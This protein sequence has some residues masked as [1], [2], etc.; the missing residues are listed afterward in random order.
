[1][2]FLTSVPFKIHFNSPFDF[3]SDLWVLEKCAILFS[4]HWWFPQ[5]LS[6]INF[7][8]S[9]TVIREYASTQEE[10]EGGSPESDGGCEPRQRWVTHKQRCPQYSLHEDLSSNHPAAVAWVGVPGRA[11]FDHFS[12]TASGV[13]GWLCG[14]HSDG[15]PNSPADTCFVPGLT[16]LVTG[17]WG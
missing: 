12:I 5:D 16:V 13:R 2:L 14:P 11:A 4:V 15:T 6:M 3:L 7:W 8:I 1:M 17:I 9:S 10:T